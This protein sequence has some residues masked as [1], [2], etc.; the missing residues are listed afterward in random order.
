MVKRREI[1]K[2]FENYKQ[3]PDIRTIDEICKTSF[4]TYE[5]QV[6]QK[7]LAE[8]IKKYDSYKSLLLYHKLGSGKTATSITMAETFMSKYPKY[9][10]NVILPARLKQN[11]Y[12]ELMS[13]ASEFKYISEVDYRIYMNP[14]TPQSHKNKIKKSFLKNVATK[15]SVMSYEKMRSLALA[16]EKEGK[17]FKEWAREFSRYKFFIV[18]EVH[19]L[20]SVNF[21]TAHYRALLNGEKTKDITH[22]GGIN[23]IL[24]K[25]LVSQ[26]HVKSKFVLL[27]A[28][29]VFNTLNQFAELVTILRPNV[30]LPKK[31]KLS[32]LINM[33]QG[34]VSYFPGTSETAYPKIVYEE[35]D[36]QMSRDQMDKLNSFDEVEGEEDMNMENPFMITQRQLSIATNRDIAHTN[37]K[38]FAPKLLAIVDNIDKDLGKHVVYCTFIKYGLEIVAKMLELRGYVNIKDVLDKKVVAV[39]YKTYAIWDGSMKDKDKE[40]VK[41]L[42]NDYSN[43]DGKIVKVI[44]GSPSIKEGVSFKHVQHL[45]LIDP[46][47]NYSAKAQVIA[48]A[49]RF[50]SHIDIPVNHPYLKREVIV[51]IYK[52]IDKLRGIMSVDEYI[53][54]EVI[55]AKYGIVEKA[56]KALQKVAFDYY[57]FRK[58]Y[59]KEVS[60]SP[61][62]TNASSHISL[63]EEDIIVQKT[64]V[65]KKKKNTCPK[66]KRPPCA[67]GYEVKDNKDGF[68]CCYKKKQPKKPKK[69]KDVYYK[70]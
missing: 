14:L 31:S 3:E 45:H 33:L 7:F 25:L 26:S 50:C 8:F 59:K 18:D 23:T 70:P 17:T 52:L 42:A 66:K 68:P 34:L 65:G 53:Y 46:V 58:L 57:L 27:T 44:L 64:H 39:E 24:F 47:W 30:T 11:F 41:R 9:T 5:F 54:N 61:T 60:V 51:H 67:T 36:V 12:D 62:D 32:D 20:V 21:K 19:N 55:P 48:R 28:T 29:P 69:E 38:E 1:S 43:L 16:S 13:P 40:L 10:V 2:V 37:P 22:L 49:V 4:D 63:G 6:Q 15:Y 56:E 35:H